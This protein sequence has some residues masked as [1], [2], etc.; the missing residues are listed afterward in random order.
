VTRPMIL[1]G[2]LLGLL[3]FAACATT[4]A[5]DWQGNALQS[6]AAE[7]LIAEDQAGWQQVW[8]KVGQAAP[9]A[10]PDETTAVA[11]FAGPKR[12]GGYSVEFVA[13]QESE[14]SFNVTYR[15]RKPRFDEMVTQALTAPYAVQLVPSKGKPV[16]VQEVR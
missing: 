12:T 13:T 7:T 14:D 16:T 2:C 4:P 11:V 5:P 8:S 6:T 1:I 3:P 15:I 10:L 9:R